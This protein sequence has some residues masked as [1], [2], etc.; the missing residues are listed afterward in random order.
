MQRQTEKRLERARRRGIPLHFRG[1]AF[2]KN[3]LSQ[4]NCQSTDFTQP[5]TNL[6]PCQT[7]VLSSSFPSHIVINAFNPTPIL[8]RVRPTQ[9]LED[10]GMDKVIEMA[11]EAAWDGCDA[12]YMS[13]ESGSNRPCLP[14]L[15]SCCSIR[16]PHYKGSEALDGLDSIQP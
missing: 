5:S 15:S 2:A 6:P 10:F 8:T 7:K 4:S 9:D 16:T 13:C 14:P 1:T 11:L 3:L 12:V